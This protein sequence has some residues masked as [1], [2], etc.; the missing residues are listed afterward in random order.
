MMEAQRFKQLFHFENNVVEYFAPVKWQKAI[1]NSDK[2][3]VLPTVTLSVVD[4]IYREGL[5][6]SIVVNNIVG[7]YTVTRPHE[8]FYKEAIEQTARLF[9]GKYG[10]QLS[11]F[12]MLLFFAEY[13]TEYKST[14]GQFDLTDVLRQC[15]KAFLPKWC[16]RLGR[17]ENQQSSNSGEITKEVGRP[18]LFRYLINEYVS[19]GIDVRTSPLVQKGILSEA[20]IKLVERGEVLPF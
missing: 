11:I 17:H 13:L 19:R 18:A 4:K 12:G 15:G 14:Y 2:C 10:S 3:L 7:L 9:V 5:S 20:D 1:T 8:P 16:S 6:V